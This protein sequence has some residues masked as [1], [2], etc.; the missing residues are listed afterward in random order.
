[1]N[2]PARLAACLAACLS[3]CAGARPHPAALE[4]CRGGAVDPAELSGLVEALTTR[5]AP[6]DFA[7]PENLDR[8]AAFVAGALRARGLEPVE[9]T[10]LVGG[11]QYRNVV[12]SV[13]PAGGE[14]I[15][16]GAHYDSAGDQPGA[17]DDASGVAGLLELARLLRASPPPVGVDLVAYTLEEPPNFRTPNMGSAVHARALAGAGVPV[18]L[19]ISLEMIGA[20]S[21]AEDSQD[22]PAVIGWFYPSRGNF[23]AVVGKWGQGG[24]VRATARAMR[25]G[26]ALPVETLTAPRFVT[27]VDF[28]DHRSYW[29]AGFPAVMITD[30]AFFRNPRY[31][32][33]LDAADTLD[34]AR[35]AEVVK[36]AAC[37]VHA[38]AR[39]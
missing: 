29:D 20:F 31:H 17:D 18:R 9:Q 25:E 16:V 34:Y 13:G 26:A 10:F 8:A 22:Y 11:R 37:A 1:M 4:A 24:D 36:G 7:H 35:M 33:P 19:M 38:A 5:F 14:R 28:S 21:D 6:R 2:R 32:T 23:V 15:V 12:A 39:R 30:T 3:A 27:G